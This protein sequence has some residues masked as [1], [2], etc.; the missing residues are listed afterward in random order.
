MPPWDLCVCVMSLAFCLCRPNVKFTDEEEARERAHQLHKLSF[1]A[2]CIKSP[3]DERQRFS[4]GLTYKGSAE[5]PHKRMDIV[6]KEEIYKGAETTLGGDGEERLGKPTEPQIIQQ[7]R[8]Q[9][10]AVGER[11]F[12]GK[13]SKNREETMKRCTEIGE[14]GER[15]RS[16]SALLGE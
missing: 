4:L 5:N 15:R 9:D 10:G 14:G 3:F 6:K 2:D 11:R 13:R 1:S 16:R 8:F 7:R 12:G